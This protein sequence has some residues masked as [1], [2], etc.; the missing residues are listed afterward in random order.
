MAGWAPCLGGGVE[1]SVQDSMRM[2]RA[3]QGSVCRLNI[4]IPSLPLDIGGIIIIPVCADTVSTL[5]AR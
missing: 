3:Q 4:R 1:D 2:F 5:P